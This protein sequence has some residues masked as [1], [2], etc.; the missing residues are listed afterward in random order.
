MFV[1]DIISPLAVPPEELP[2]HPN[3]PRGMNFSNV[4][5]LVKT[6]LREE[7]LRECVDSLRNCFNG[8]QILV[9]ANGHDLSAG[10]NRMVKACQTKY[11]LIGDDDFRYFSNTRLDWLRTLLE[12]TGADIAAGAVYQEK[13]IVHYEGDF[14]A[15]LDGGITYERIPEEYHESDEVRYRRTDLA[16]NFFMARTE[17]LLRCPWDERLHGYEHEDFFLMA[18]EAGLKTVYCPDVFVGHRMRDEEDPKEYQV[19]RHDRSTASIFREKWLGSPYNFR[20]TRDVC[21]RRQELC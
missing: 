18:A 15:Q 3:V 12:T 1:R 2:K 19:K 5:A 10:R 9:D 11:C 21:G 20:Y 14:T 4:T 13:R 17:S 16:L 6:F 7:Y 8:I